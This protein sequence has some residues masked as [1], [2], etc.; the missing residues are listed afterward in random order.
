MKGVYTMKLLWQ[1][2]F[3]DFD[4]KRT[5]PLYYRCSVERNNRILNCYFFDNGLG[6]TE[7]AFRLSDGQIL[8]WGANGST[9]EYKERYQKTH[10]PY[11]FE[12]DTFV[13]GEYTISHY[14]Q[15]GYMCKKKDQLLW[16]IS[17]KGY[18]YTD[19]IRNQS[20]IVFGTS[21]QGGHFYSLNIDTG[22]I[23]FDFNTK[24]TSVFYDI[25]NS[26]YF[27]STDKNSTQILRI[28]YFGNT[29][30]KIE[31][32]GVYYDGY[33]LFRLCE[34]VLCVTTLHKTRK[35]KYELFTPIL[36]CIQL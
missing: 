30:E 9:K 16:K 22:E 23:V 26:F 4:L 14:G 31:I 34:D 7:I 33:S 11:H 20:N 2:K 15:W 35:D 29:L 36:S 32:E 13:F 19:M 8:T 5:S 12:S 1:N 21:G 17:L 24:G 28:D 27:C 6:I 25:N 3:E 10:K 18:L